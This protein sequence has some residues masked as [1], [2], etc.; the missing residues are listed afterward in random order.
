VAVTKHVTFGAF[1]RDRR[2]QLQL[3]QKEVADRVAVRLKEADRRGFD[4]SYLSKIEN[5]RLPPPSTPAILALAEV[6]TT[7]ADELLALAGKTPPDIGE[8][9]KESEGARIFFRSAVN[10]RLSEKDWKDLLE[11]MR[12]RKGKE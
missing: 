11:T 12:R 8:K 3:T 9:L 5:D 4:I 6:L 1:I 10:L 7:G 2:K